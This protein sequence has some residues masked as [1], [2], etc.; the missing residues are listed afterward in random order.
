ME[1]HKLQR[2]HLAFLKIEII[3][4]IYRHRPSFEPIF[5]TNIAV[6]SMKSIFASYLI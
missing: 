1:L 3:K 4:F 6:L 5:Y 2:L